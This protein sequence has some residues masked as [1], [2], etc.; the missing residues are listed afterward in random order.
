MAR[1]ALEERVEYGW[2]RRRARGW[3]GLTVMAGALLAAT[4]FLPAVVSCN[5]D[6][7][8]LDATVETLKGPWGSEMAQALQHGS[9]L[10]MYVPAYLVGALLA[11]AGVGRLMGWKWSPRWYGRVALGVVLVPAVVLPVCIL[12]ELV[13]DGQNS[14]LADSSAWAV[15]LVCLAAPVWVLF[16]LVMARRR[17]ELRHARHQFIFS[18]WMVLWFG[19]WAADFSS[20]RYGVILSFVASVGLLAA[21]AGEARVLTGQGWMRTLGQLMIGRLGPMVDGRGRC[22]QCGYLLYGLAERRCPECGRGFSPDDVGLTPADLNSAIP[23]SISGTSYNCPGGTTRGSSMNNHP[24]S[25]A[26]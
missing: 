16:C 13:A 20:A 17:R 3:R 5:A 8:P 2:A 22:P 10:L 14:D 24:T 18:L 25:G 11:L 12:F 6:V 7:V 19:I 21:A 23:G 15:I 9:A 26:C 4:F 1:D